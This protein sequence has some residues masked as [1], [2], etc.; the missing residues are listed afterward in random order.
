[1]R[2]FRRQLSPGYV[3]DPHEGKYPPPMVWSEDQCEIYER[4]AENILSGIEDLISDITSRDRDA[5]LLHLL[6]EKVHASG[7]CTKPNQKVIEFELLE[8][9]TDL[10]YS[11]R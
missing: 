3:P 4:Y 6:L 9:Y 8:Y 10:C 7:R 1:M 11:M 2:V 5:I